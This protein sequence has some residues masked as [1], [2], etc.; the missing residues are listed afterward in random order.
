MSIKLKDYEQSFERLKFLLDDVKKTRALSHLRKKLIL[1][2]DCLTCIIS[3]SC[4][5]IARING[6]L[7]TDK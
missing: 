6:A 5:D 2:R 3:I 7:K 4:D 1:I